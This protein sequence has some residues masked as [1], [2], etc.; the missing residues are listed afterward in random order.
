MRD[1]PL[2]RQ[3]VLEEALRFR[4][5]NPMPS[6][7]VEPSYPAQA[8]RERVQMLLQ[9]TYATSNGEQKLNPNV[10][11]AVTMAR[12]MMTTLYSRTPWSD[13]YIPASVQ[14]GGAAH[15]RAGPMYS[16]S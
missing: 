7:Q 11:T 4:G 10:T 15:T 8:V 12:P 14:A 13:V 6:P 2:V 9:N 3:G 5:A 1:N 16:L